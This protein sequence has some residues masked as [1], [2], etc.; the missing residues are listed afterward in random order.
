MGRRKERTRL[1]LIAEALKLADLRLRLAADLGPHQR[2][3]ALKELIDARE[4]LIAV[5]E[6]VKTGEYPS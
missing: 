6:E 1:E 3:E 5:V 2:T 4:M